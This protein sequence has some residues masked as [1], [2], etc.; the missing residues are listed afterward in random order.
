MAASETA[1]WP[2]GSSLT[3]PVLARA[4]YA[5]FKGMVPRPTDPVPLPSPGRLLRT[6]ELLTW[7][8]NPN[9]LALKWVAEGRLRK[10]G[11]GGIWLVLGP[12][13][14]TPPSPTLKQW[15]QV[16]LQHDRFVITGPVIWKKLGFIVGNRVDSPWFREAMVYNRG[17]G[18]ERMF[19]RDKILFFRR[20]FPVSP[21]KEWFVVDMLEHGVDCGCNWNAAMEHHLI[22][23]LQRAKLNPE[24]LLEAAKGYGGKQNRAYLRNLVEKA[25]R[26][27][28]ILKPE[29]DIF[30]SQPTENI[31]ERP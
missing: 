12:G 25:A 30:L 6:K 13:G 8:S 20:R 3:N 19:D 7:D 5:T 9:R 28:P 22:L 16:F 4:P 11:E 29:V 31:R 1:S 26:P 2:S 23:A 10:F 15:V 18:V 24:N 17:R 14:S 27:L 21:T